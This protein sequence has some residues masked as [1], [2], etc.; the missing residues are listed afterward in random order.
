MLFNLQKLKNSL[1]FSI[2]FLF[3]FFPF[4]AK[5]A[6]LIPCGG[7]GE[8]P[9]QFC[10]IFILLR[11][12]YDF[13]LFPTDLNGKFPVVGWMALAMF[14][15]I[16]LKYFFAQGDYYKLKAVKKL[17]GYVILGLILV[18]SSWLITDFVITSLGLKENY[19]GNWNE[20][21]CPTNI[22]PSGGGSP[23][24]GGGSAGSGGGGSS[25]GPP[26]SPPP[27]TI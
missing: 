1:F 27:P 9:C 7:P 8:P 26:P 15:Y 24:T 11:N 14:I 13:L 22:T 6:G 10:H 5:A 4:F 12:I 16:G 18:Y 3:L 19:L 21:K 20:I 17:L 2:S 23:G 25:P